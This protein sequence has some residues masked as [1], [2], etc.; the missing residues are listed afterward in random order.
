MISAARRC[1]RIVDTDTI[2]SWWCCRG[3][4]IVSGPASSP[5]V[6]SWWRSSMMRFRVGSVAR[7]EGKSSLGRLDLLIHSTAGFVMLAGIGNSRLHS[8]M[9]PTSLSRCTPA[10]RPARSA[11]NRWPPVP[12]THMGRVHAGVSIRVRSGCDPAVTGRTSSSRSLILLVPIGSG[13]T[14]SGSRSA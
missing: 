13:E 7:L 1:H 2:T 6:L 8:Q 5:R 12:T 9:S 10:L 3:Q 11:S 14:W 4:A